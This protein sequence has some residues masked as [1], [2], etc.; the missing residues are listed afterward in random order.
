M[1]LDLFIKWYNCYDSHMIQS[2][3]ESQTARRE[4]KMMRLEWS[5][6]FDF[7]LAQKMI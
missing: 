1:S 5:K 7:K 6:R 3:R 2:K 4:R